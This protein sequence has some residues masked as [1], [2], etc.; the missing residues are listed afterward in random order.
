MIALRGSAYND[1]LSG[2]NNAAGTTEYFEGRAGDDRIDGRGGF[3]IASYFFDSVGTLGIA[4]NMAAGT[5]SYRGTS[6]TTDPIG[7]DTLINIEGIRGTTGNDVYDATGFTGAS[8]DT[9]LA[10]TFNQFQGYAGD[11]DI[12]GNGNTTLLYSEAT[13]A[14]TVN[15][16][17]GTASGT[18]AGIGTDTIHGGIAVVV[19]SNYD[20]TFYGTSANE[21]F[22][23]GSL[24]F[25]RVRY[26]SVTMSGL[27]I[28][29]QLAL[30]TVTGAMLQVLRSSGPTRF[31]VSKKSPGR[32]RPIYS[33][34]SGSVRQART[35]AGRITVPTMT[36][37]ATAETI[38]L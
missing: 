32:M 31:E 8:T 24:G 7:H 23:G 18:G 15:L 25:D 17:A 38:S 27:G 26:D 12:T 35:E 2:S 9:G 21:V 10:S 3:D 14:V 29:V 16:Q 33:T 11:D 6:A 20:D 13:A 5:V 36:S 37:K 1:T 28:N 30:G 34:R 19:G 22:N 4:V